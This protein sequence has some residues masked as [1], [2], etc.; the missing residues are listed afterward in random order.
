MPVWDN[1]LPSHKH[2]GEYSQLRFENFY[3]FP[4]ILSDYF[5]DY[6]LS[7][8]YLKVC[9]IVASSLSP[10][11]HVFGLWEEA[12]AFGENSGWR[13]EK[14]VTGTMIYDIRKDMILDKICPAM[15]WH[16]IQVYPASCLK[17]AVMDSSPPATLHR[18][19]AV[20]YGSC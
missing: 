3:Q 16:L 5:N 9:F 11:T 7:H 12:S 18:N 4:A 10:K 2:T 14:M 20:Y 19:E 17:A 13:Q 1:H 8:F 6:L 15:S